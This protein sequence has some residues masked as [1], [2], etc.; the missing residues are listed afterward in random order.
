[1]LRVA[2]IL[3]ERFGTT[4]NS[5]GY[6][7]LKHVRIIQ[8]DGINLDSLR[9]CLS[10]LYHNGFAADNIAFGMGGG[11]LQQLNRDTQRFAMKCSAMEV[12]GQWRDVYKQPVGD[13]TKASKKGHFALVECDGQISTLSRQADETVAGDL[14]QPV[15][16]NGAL[17]RESGFDEIRARAVDGLNRLNGYAAPL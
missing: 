13:S 5:K 7:V 2:Q 16:R 17:L 11:L 10:T 9:N 15:F 6:R 14:L 4:T 12:Q 3:A 1:M 8:G